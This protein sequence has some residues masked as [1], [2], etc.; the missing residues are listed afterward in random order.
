MASSQRLFIFKIVFKRMFKQCLA[1][2]EVMELR[3]H[4]IPILKTSERGA[5]TWLGLHLFKVTF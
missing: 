1:I 3:L 5:F 4:L 2:N